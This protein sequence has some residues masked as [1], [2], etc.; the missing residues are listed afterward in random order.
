M[1]KGKYRKSV[2]YYLNLLNN[3][4]KN[5]PLYKI[6]NNLGVAYQNL[7]QY[8]KSIDILNKGLN[9]ELIAEKIYYNLANNYFY[10]NDYRNANK[11]YKKALSIDEEY[12]EAQIGLANS[13]VYL[14]MFDQ[15]EKAYKKSWKMGMFDYS[16]Y[17]LNLSFDLQYRDSHFKK[18]PKI[19]KKLAEDK[20]NPILLFK[21]GEIYFFQG[22]FKKSIKYYKRAYKLDKKNCDYSYFVA[23]TF[24]LMGKFKQSSEYYKIS[25]KYEEAQYQ[26]DILELS[27]LMKKLEQRK[28]YY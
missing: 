5:V 2:K 10:L 1:N 4:K 3:N 11:F 21:M 28:I 27:K 19:K 9:K 15:A 18:E 14:E 8:K 26:W 7:G 25:S 22:L 13:Y 16:C 6:Y 12:L 17:A 24:A 20:N 23:N